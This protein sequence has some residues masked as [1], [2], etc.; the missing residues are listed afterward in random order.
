MGE[1]STIEGT[2]ENVVF[3]NE[4]NGYTVLSLLTDQGEVVTVVG[5]IPFA[6]AGESMTVTGVWVNHPTY[7]VQMTAELVERRMPQD[8]EGIICYLASGVLKGVGPATATRLVDKFGADTLRVIEEEPEKLTTLKGITSKKAMEIS[9]AF[10]SLTGLR[11]VME[12]LS[13][14]DLPV[15]LAMGLLRAYGDETLKKLKDN[16]YLL[17]DER[18]GVDFSAADEIALAMGFDGDSP[19]R[20]E[21]AVLYELNHNLSNGH[22]FLPRPKL[23][24]ATME[25]IGVDGEA[26]EKALDDL[27]ERGA[28]VCRPIANVQGCYLR[29]MYE[30]EVYVAKRLAAACGDDW[31]CGKNADRI[32]DD[33]QKQQGVAYAPEQRRAVALAAE[34]GI[35]LLT[36]SPGTG[37]TTSVRGIVTLFERMGLDVLL[38]A[39]TGRAAQRMSQLCG[40]DAQTVH[41]AL[42]MSWN[43]LTGEVTFRKSEKE[44]LE[45]DAVIVDEM[46]MVDLELMASLLRAMRPG[47]R[48]VMVGDP[49]QL[50]SVG[51]GN[52]LGDLLR[53]GVIPSV[54]LTEIFRQAEKSAII[55]N[56]HAV[57]TGRPPELK[58]T[59]NDF[60]FLCRRAPDRLVQ[61]VVEL[62]RQRLPNNMG[63]PAEQIQVLSPTRK[64]VCGTVNLN[65]ALQAALNPPAAGKRQKLWGDMVFREG[66]RVMQ[67]RN[68][69]DVVWEKDDGSM[70]AGIFNGD[71]GVIQEIDPSGELITIQFDDRTCVYTAD[72]LNQLDMAYAMTVHKAQGSEYRCVV[73][74]SAAVAPA[75]MVR[76]VLYT[77]I[78]R[79]RELLV[80]VGDDVAPGQMAAND[81][82]QRRYSGLRR[83]LRE[84]A[85]NHGME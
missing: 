50:P 51:A 77:A 41:R 81:R 15:T 63:I 60:F 26:V 19:C 62:C 78:T 3:Q 4:E 32:I 16:P 61:T 66:D 48:L 68:N 21:A 38:L 9:A 14:Y 30:A 65:R 42:G 1:R 71:V 10:R 40:R 17:T 2:V 20:T 6:A 57:N 34:R 49:D 74:V 52:V 45:A 39:P 54:S 58:N 53:S 37:K 82:Q 22:V 12:F 55:R 47:C 31:D 7:G 75:L 13:R 84:E 80:L 5:C 44:P 18:C 79:A 8:E 43:E 25:L 24:A 64:G 69:Y 76:G 59:Q 67:T 11:R 36:G 35:L 28:I 23:L 29:R 70:G 85:A 46:S 72:L 83:R 73:L 33:I 27:C 56:A